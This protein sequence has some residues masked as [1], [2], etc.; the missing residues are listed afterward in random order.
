MRR[1]WQDHISSGFQS[2][3]SPI[4]FVEG[5]EFLSDV[6]LIGAAAEEDISIWSADAL[7]ELRDVEIDVQSHYAKFP[8]ILRFGKVQE[9]DLLRVVLEEVK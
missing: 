7:M 2:K 1:P 3:G 6:V 5:L 9:V 4:P 8:A